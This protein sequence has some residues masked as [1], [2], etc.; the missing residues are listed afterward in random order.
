MYKDRGQLFVGGILVI[1]GLLLLLGKLLHVNLWGILW[2]AALI[3]LG[4]WLVMRPRL[5]QEGTVVHQRLFGDIDRSGVWEVS[6]E[7][8]WMFAGDIDLDMSQAEF[9]LGETRIRCYGF[10]ADLKVRVP[11][12][13][14]VKVVASN[15]AGDVK[16]FG[17][18]HGGLL[19]PVRVASA[20]YDSA[21]SK[22]LLETSYFASDVKVTRG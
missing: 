17:E 10:A 21:E 16:L 18:K 22:I 19:S 5:V 11:E 12:E 9:P 14:G 3:G 7:E 13:V 20:N 8:I 6:D 4:V 2:P 1:A 15:F